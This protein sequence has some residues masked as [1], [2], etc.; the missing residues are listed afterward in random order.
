MSVLIV[1]N[2]PHEG[3]GTIEDYLKEK[4]IPYKIVYMAQEACQDYGNYDVLVIMGGY[5]SVNETAEYPFIAKEEEMVRSFIDG[6]KKVLGIC[7]G[8]Q[9]IAKA[10]GKK[11]YRGSRPEIGWYDIDATREGKANRAFSRLIVDGTDLLT[12]F[13]WHG[14]TFDLP[15]GALR[16]ASSG[17]YPNQA[18]CYQDSVYAFQFHIEVKKEMIYEWMKDEPVDLEALKAVTEELFDAYL[19]RAQGFYREFFA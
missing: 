11:V 17:L 7:L 4:G 16:L 19:V 3:P 15:E 5:M 9:L 14:E 18:F 12:V 2:V 8:S 10:L 6:K 13:H 1:K